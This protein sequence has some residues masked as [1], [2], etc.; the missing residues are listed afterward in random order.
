[1]A[2]RRQ[3]E[4][5]TKVKDGA[6]FRQQQRCAHCGHSL[7]NVLDRAHHVIP[8]QSGRVNN[9]ADDFLRTEDNCVYLCEECHKAAHEHGRFRNGAVALPD[10]YKHSHGHDLKKHK[11]WEGRILAYLRGRGF[12]G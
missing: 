4:F 12:P 9:P 2:P 5:D 7:L 6:F 3:F 10:F 1:M 8:N 11:E